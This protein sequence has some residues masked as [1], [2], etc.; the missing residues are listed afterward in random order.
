MAS[1]VQARRVDSGPERA[2]KL[3]E[4]RRWVKRADRIAR[5]VIVSGGIAVVGAVFLIL[6]LIGA[7]SIPIWQKA[8]GKP[9]SALEFA[10]AG[11]DPILMVIAD[12]YREILVVLRA[13]GVFQQVDRKTARVGR[14]IP[15]PGSDG[16]RVTAVGR[17]ASRDYLAV[18]FEDGRAVVLSARLRVDFAPSGRTSNFDVRQ[19]AHV[20]LLPGG[21]P[22]RFVAAAR[23][24]WETCSSALRAPPI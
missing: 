23:E 4:T 17:I 20:Q 9:E 8:T 1:A 24:D 19:T 15:V 5:A 14:S 3:Q 10:T 12:P 21:I 7:E 18:G 16:K 6:I 22:V 13:S 11:N 2:P